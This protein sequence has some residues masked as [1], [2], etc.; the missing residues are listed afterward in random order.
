MIFSRQLARKDVALAH[1]SSVVP[2]RIFAVGRGQRVKDAPYDVW[3][4]HIEANLIK[5]AHLSLSHWTSSR[6]PLRR[7]KLP[8]IERLLFR[9]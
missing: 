8:A 6:K 1:V 3:T 4:V 7:R 2:L 9:L 5:G